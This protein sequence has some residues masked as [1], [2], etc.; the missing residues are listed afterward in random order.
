MQSV[1]H[2][3]LER[4][5]PAISVLPQPITKEQGQREEW[6]EVVGEGGGNG[7]QSQ[8]CFVLARKGIP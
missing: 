7:G 1:G 6:V 8:A 4:A 3:T 5:L 2:R